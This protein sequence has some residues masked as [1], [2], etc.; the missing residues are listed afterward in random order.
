MRR[1]VAAEFLRNTAPD[2]AVASLSVLFGEGVQAAD[3]A[4][5]TAADAIT[6]AISADDDTLDYPTRARLYA[7]AVQHGLGP[8]ARLFFGAGR[9]GGKHEQAAREPERPLVPRGRTLTLG[10]RKSVARTHEREVMS[11]VLRDP[12]PDVVAILLD[13]PHATER[14]VLTI[15]VRRPAPAASLQAIATH[16]RWRVRY[17]IKH[18]LV[19]NPYT[20]VPIALRLVATLRA[21]DLRGIAE[22][23]SLDPLVRQQAAEL[24]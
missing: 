12:H 7:S 16:P 9:P 1:V 2:E 10:E 14:D 6:A 5:L 3:P 17:A 4:Y 21:A 22:D 8:I 11:H 15:A 20:P 13:N 18:A 23:A 19:L 24:V